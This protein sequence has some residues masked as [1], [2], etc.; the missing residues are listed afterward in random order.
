MNTTLASRAA[1]DAWRRIIAAVSGNWRPS[2]GQESDPDLWYLRT[3]V[4]VR[5]DSLEASER[6]LAKFLEAH[7][8]SLHAL[9]EHGSILDRMGQRDAALAKYDLARRGR[10]LI[11]RG[12]P[13]RPFFTR[14]CTT[15]VAEIDGYTHVLRADTSKRGV[16]AHVARGHAY[17]ATRRP[18]LAL[19]DYSQALKLAPQ[20]TGL[21]VAKGEALAALGLHREALQVLDQAVACRPRDPEALSSRA[22]VHLALGRGA[23]ADAD[24]LRQ[25]ELLPRE[26]HAARASVLLRLANYEMALAELERAIATSPGDPYLY[27]YFLASLRR[28]GRSAE[29]RPAPLDIWPGPLIAL[30]HGKLP[31]NEVLQSADSPE[32]RAEALFQLGVWA[33]DHDRTEAG[34]LWGQAV[35]I[36]P[37]D[38]IEHAAAQHE[39]ERLHVVA[40]PINLGGAAEREAIVMAIS[41]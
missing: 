3:I 24:W 22:F 14:H 6:R 41:K 4:R 1:L 33:Y 7:P 27:L 39:I 19:F 2:P 26:R 11:K 35:E 10:Q 15:S 29:P 5:T 23:K 34:R 20:A 36:A 16:F 28:L 25:L 21:L 32:R 37:P 38:T 8:T 9:E 40:Q 13:D 30:H 12:M 18:R 31:P 17:L